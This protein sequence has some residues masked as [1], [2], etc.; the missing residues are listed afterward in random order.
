MPL[1]RNKKTGRT[2]MILTKVEAKKI[3]VLRRK[4]KQ[5]EFNKKLKVRRSKKPKRKIKGEVNIFRVG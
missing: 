5:K 4:K 3:R 1:L 2:T